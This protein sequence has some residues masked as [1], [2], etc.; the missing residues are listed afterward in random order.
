MLTK[1]CNSACWPAAWLLLLTC[2]TLGSLRAQ[3]VTIGAI[4][5]PVVAPATS[6]YLYGPLYRSSTA[7][8]FNYSRYAHLYQAT[9]LNIPTGAVITEL[10]WL[11]STGAELTGSNTF[12][13]LLAN[14]SLTT[15]P[16]PQPWNTLSAGATPV[17]TSANQQVTGAAGT[18]FSVTLNQPFVYTGGNLLI[19]TNH[20]KR[21]TATA[22]LNFVTNP[23]AGLALGFASGTAPTPAT[24]LTTT[25]G[26]RRPTLR[27]SFVPGGPCTAPPTAGT[28][29]AASDTLCAGGS[30]TL[31][32]NG[33]SYGQNQTYQFQQS[34]DGVTYTDI[35]GATSPFFVTGALSAPRFYRARLTCGGQTATSAPVRVFVQAPVYATLPVQQSFEQTWL[36][37]CGLRDAP[38]AS[39]RSNP[40]V[41]NNAWRRYDDPSGAG[42]T[43]PTFGGYTPQASLG[44]HSARFHS[45]IATAGLVGTLDLYVNLSAPGP[46]ELTF[47]HINTNGTDS[48]FV[49][50][51]TDGGATFGRPLLRLGSAALASFTSESLPLTTTSATAVVRFLARS[52]NGTTD[53]GLDNV[54]IAATSSCLAPA[55]LQATGITSTSATI[56]WSGAGGPYTLEYGPEGFTPGTGTMV[57]S[58][59]AASFT[60]N[61]LSAFTEYDVYV[62]QV[63]G[64]GQTST[65]SPLTFTTRISND[66]CATALTLT[67][68]A[69][70]LAV[71]GSVFQ[72]TASAGAP[73]CTPSVGTPD[74]DVWFTFVATATAH[75]IRL[76]EGVGFDGAMQL[77]TGTCGTLVNRQCVDATTANGV[78]VIQA[79]GLTVGDRYYVRVYS[80]T[81]TAPTAANSSFSI[82]VSA[83]ATIP[84]NDN[85]AGAISLASRNTCSPL[86]GTTFRATA[87]AG[88]PVCTPALGTADDDVWYSFVATAASHDVRVDELAGFDAVV[89]VLAGTCGTLSSVQCTDRTAAGGVEL[90]RVGGLTVGSTYF[91][92]VYSFSNTAPTISNSNFTICITNAPPP[93]ANDDCA[94]ATPLP[95]RIG[96]TSCTSPTTSTNVG[97]SASAGVPAPTACTTPTSGTA[98]YQGGDVWF[99][100]TVPPAG[101]IRLETGPVASSPILDTGMAVYA[102]TC[103]SLTQIECDDNDSPNGNFSLISLTGRSPGEVL[104]VRVWEAGNDLEGSFTI[105][106]T[107]PATCIVPAAPG[108]DN[109]SATG[110]DLTWGGAAAAGE[111]FTVEYGLAG[112]AP[113]SGTTLMNLTTNLTSLTG[114]QADTE[115]CFYVTKVCGG[116]QGNSPTAGPICFRTL[117]AVP[118][119]DEPCGAIVLAVSSSAPTYLAATTVGATTS[120]DNDLQLPACSP[121]LLP[122]DVWF[123][124]TAPAPTVYL[125]VTGNPA[126]MVRVFEGANCQASFTLL[127]CQGVGNNQA[128]GAITATGLMVGQRY[129][130][131]VSGYGSGDV[132]GAFSIAASTVTLASRSSLAAALSV[133]PNPSDTGRLTVQLSGGQ[134]AVAQATLLNVLGQAVITQSLSLHAGAATETLHVAALAPGLYTLQLRV[135]G[136]LLSRK[137]VLK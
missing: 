83:P 57:A 45:Y 102:G 40:V 55:G 54:Q 39:W 106:A 79:T 20:E 53:I 109:I 82:C 28:T 117:Q 94:G 60:I 56:S 136:V 29:R 38:S 31:F 115:Y 86:L 3:T 119:N 25:Y 120:T 62:T 112:F 104:Y 24:N 4:A 33:A 65:S 59:T 125:N 50:L 66:D 100:V 99:E 135:G 101:I 12:S 2:L 7:S 118:A 58:Q 124:F 23:A 48:L 131:A 80:W 128:A 34:T 15:L 130:V 89:Q 35:A 113:G 107:A 90:F 84:T 47:D 74:D 108:A 95:V 52:D 21:G 9:E 5:V 71:R 122:K 44:S 17:Y 116:T 129:F 8:T 1:L 64:P 63:C 114:L 87:S 76:A 121:A 133:Y 85:C 16:S 123:A 13:V 32:L 126:G 37:I 22:A 46:K 11:K 43:S 68:G 19:L 73:V 36:S 132:Q 10:A 70:C 92:R 134:A 67:P 27:I 127:G 18:Y 137:V 81:A 49:L 26:N 78:E 98:N 61:G 6:S 111:S 97:A 51:S 14:S 105:C 110:A 72:A 91:V 103:G 75:D 77:L 30:T 42:W 93:P 96:A 41:G 69:T 88:A